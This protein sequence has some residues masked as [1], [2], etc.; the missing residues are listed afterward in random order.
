MILTPENEASIARENAVLKE[1]NRRLR[2][3]LKNVV[4]TVDGKNVDWWCQRAGYYRQR[5]A[6]LLT[7]AGVPVQQIDLGAPR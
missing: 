4:D 1:E 7:A 5:L 2:E 6:A 3:Q